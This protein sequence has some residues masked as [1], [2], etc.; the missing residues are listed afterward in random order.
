[1]DHNP[2]TPYPPYNPA[3]YPPGP[4]STYEPNHPSQFVN[5]P[6]EDMNLGNPYAPQHQQHDAYYGQPRRTDDNVSAPVPDH[7]G[8]EHYNFAS[9]RGG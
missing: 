7:S 5:P 2:N 9:A 3:D 6:H 8:N 4:E 1:V